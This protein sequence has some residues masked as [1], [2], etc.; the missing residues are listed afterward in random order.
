MI[1]SSSTGG[2]GAAGAG[3]QLGAALAPQHTD[4][5]YCS[6]LRRRNYFE[7]QEPEPKFSVE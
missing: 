4:K 5:S 6:V 7:D 1:V 2:D 3:E